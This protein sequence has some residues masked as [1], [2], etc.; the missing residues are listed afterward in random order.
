MLHVFTY[1]YHKFKPDV[2]KYTIHGAY[3][4]FLVHLYYLSLG[5]VKKG[6]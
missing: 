5:D 6:G 3:G 1:M 2:G 4:I